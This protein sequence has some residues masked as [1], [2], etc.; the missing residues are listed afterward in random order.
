[1]PK[2]ELHAHLSGS[3][4]AKT[5]EELVDLH[6]KTFPDEK[7]PAEADT[8]KNMTATNSSFDATYAIF[9]VA[10]SIVDHP[11][12]VTLATTR[13]IEEF[14][15][16]G[17]TFLE[18]RSTPRRVA[19][20]MTKEE[21]VEAVVDAIKKCDDRNLSIIVKYLISIDR[22]GSVADAEEALKLCVEMHGKYPSVV[23]GLDFSGDARV[24]DA[25]NYLDV[26]H[27]AKDRGLFVTVHLAEVPN[28]EEVANFLSEF[29]PHRVG[30]GSCIH[31]DFGGD[32]QLWKTFVS[33]Q[34]TIPVEICLTSNLVS[35]IGTV[36][37]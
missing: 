18:L 2:A 22:R 1:M 12:A 14:C 19:G 27:S 9:R 4:T 17:V 28:V 3:L 8:F 37:I 15:D 16:D 36:S 29:R 21:Y 30:H 10:Q 7:L 26:L 13:V 11:D 6:R 31:P 5:I 20:K 23:V 33:M 34:P 35:F 25:K 32:D 24:N